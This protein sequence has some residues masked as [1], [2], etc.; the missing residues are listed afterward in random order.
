MSIK[1]IGLSGWIVI[2]IAVLVILGMWRT[3]SDKRAISAPAAEYLAPISAG[4]IPSRIGCDVGCDKLNSFEKWQPFLADVVEVHRRQEKCRKVEY[5][6]VSNESDPQNPVFFVGCENANGDLYNTD[7]T[8]AQV[9]SKLIARSDDVSKKDAYS[10]C[11]AELYKHFSRQ[12][13]SN[14]RHGFF[15]SANGR[16]RVVYD[17]TVDGNERMANC[18]V[19]HDFVE[20]TIVK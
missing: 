18:L 1:K 12:R 11:D 19:G 16:A 20:F 3:T 4:A 14:V 8:K 13:Q 17:L 2:S 5:V 7:Y 10:K 15:V 9:D 6:S